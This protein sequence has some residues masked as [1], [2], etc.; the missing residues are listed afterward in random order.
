LDL[1]F[2]N[3]SGVFPPS[4]GSSLTNL[5]DLFL[6]SNFGMQG[7]IPSTLGNLVNLVRLD[8]S[9]SSYSGAIPGSSF[10]NL[11]NLR[12]LGLSNNRLS[13]SIPP[14]LGT[15]L[16]DLFT[17]DLENNV[18]SGAVPF[19]PS[20]VQRMGRNLMVS[21]NPGLCYTSV[22]EMKFPLQLA[23]CPTNSS[24][25]SSSS[26]APDSNNSAAA[27]PMSSEEAKQ[28]FHPGLSLYPFCT[29]FWSCIFYSTRIS[30]ALLK[31]QEI[32]LH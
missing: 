5:E 28:E 6:S 26:V 13:G 25:S 3:F 29:G 27:A 18:L 23:P 22:V 2:N 15:D 11:V 20:F 17:L 12:Y 4:L 14:E 9:S 32:L 31:W 16:P 21:G 8:L 19:A 10:K 30:K 24:S 7:L 1:S